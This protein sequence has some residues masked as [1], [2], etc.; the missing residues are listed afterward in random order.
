MISECVSFGSAKVEVLMNRQLK[1]PNKFEEL[2]Q[3]LEDQ[4]AV[5]MFDGTLG[6]ADTKID[7]GPTLKSI[8]EL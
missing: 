2:I 3:G 5:H 6:V 7:I 4:N 8:M 1:S